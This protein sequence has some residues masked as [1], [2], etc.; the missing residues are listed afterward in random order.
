MIFTFL[1]MVTQRQSLHYSPFPSLVMVQFLAAFHKI[2]SH[3]LDCPFKVEDIHTLQH[4]L[5]HVE[6]WL[7]HWV[8]CFPLIDF[9]L[10]ALSLVDVCLNRRLS[11][12][13]TASQVWL[14]EG[15]GSKASPSLPWCGMLTLWCLDSNLLMPYSWIIW[16]QDI[17]PSEEISSSVFF[18]G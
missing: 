2:G 15:G 9:N 8:F 12:A 16:K 1:K 17:S 3:Q 13:S 4:G 6:S 5:C 11:E 14:T 7:C 18:H 10:H